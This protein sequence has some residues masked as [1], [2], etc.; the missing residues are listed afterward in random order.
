MHLFRV[1]LLFKKATLLYI[2][3]G[4]FGI[5]G[6]VF[7]AVSPQYMKLFLNLLLEKKFSLSAG[8]MILLLETGGSLLLAISRVLSY[9]LKGHLISSLVVSFAK[10]ALRRDEAA[11]ESKSA[12][13]LFEEIADG[14]ANAQ[15]GGFLSVFKAV[16][17]AFGAFLL[18]P[19]IGI[20][21]LS[22]FTISGLLAFMNARLYSKRYS[23][24]LKY[25]MQFKSEVIDTFRGIED[26]KLYCAE[27]EEKELFSRKAKKLK[28]LTK[29]LYSVDFIISGLLQRFVST[30]FLLLVV[31]RAFLLHDGGM[32]LAGARYFRLFAKEKASMLN[33]IDV[34]KQGNEAAKVYLKVVERSI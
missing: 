24:V 8:L 4:V 2:F 18:D 19:V 3:C 30:L 6:T 7:L 33:V 26:I 17:Y 34:L 23:E 16:A 29:G 15:L 21:N 27:N 11:V 20:M 14:I 1:M 5:L 32:I 31:L 9:R 25:E 28:L 22:F 12:V 10:N 13:K